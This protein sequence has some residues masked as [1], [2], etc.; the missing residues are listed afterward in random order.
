MSLL[1][2]LLKDHVLKSLCLSQI[3]TFI[4]ILARLKD[5]IILAQPIYI[6]ITEAPLVL[7]PQIKTFVAE[8]IGIPEDSVNGCWTVLKDDIWEY[9]TPEKVEAEE[10]ELFARHG[11]KRGISM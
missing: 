9:P 8:C 6:A 3:V 2:S 1:R 7:P 4:Q 5:D 11:W 10:E